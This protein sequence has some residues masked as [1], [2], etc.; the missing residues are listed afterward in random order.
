MLDRGALLLAHD[1]GLG[2]TVSS[3]AVAEELIDTGE[4]ESVLVICPASIKWQWKRQIEEFTDGALVMV[5]E[6]NQGERR[7]Q[8]RK[9]K[10]GDVEYV[11]MNYEQIVI[12]WDIVRF[13][14]WDAVFCDE[15]VAIKNPGAK[16]SRHVKRLRAPYKYGLSGKPIENRPEELFSIM[17]W[18]DPTVLGSFREF[19]RTYI[20]RKASG[21]V[22]YYKNLPLLRKTMDE[23]IHRKTRHD[24]DVRD[25]MPAVASK[26]YLIDFD[27][28]SQR[29]YNKIV[30]E[31]LEVIR[32]AQ[33]F[34]TFNL[35]SHYAGVDDGGPMGEIMPRLM[36]LRMLC[37]HPK[38]L[39]HSADQ[40]D[41][42][43]T[44]AGSKYIS[45]LRKTGAIDKLKSAPKMSVTLE[46]IDDIL[47]ASSRNKVV[48]FSFFKP[49][50]AIL[51]GNL[52]VDHEMFTGDL[53]PRERDA[54]LERFQKDTRCRVLLSSDAGGVGVD[55]PAANYLIS[56]D[57]P[58]SAGKFD[59]R[60]GRIVRIS[61]K[62]PEVTLLSMLMRNS[63][64]ERMFDMLQQKSA[65]GAAWLDGKRVNK[66]GEF[67]LTLGGLAEYLENHQ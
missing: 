20:R 26:S 61:T 6:G 2:K 12:D 13:L 46:E 36:A 15:I 50:L 62:W 18:I 67:H 33:S 37:D 24:K 55:M 8:Y 42:P 59:Q 64:E 4:A 19:D 63:I 17:E 25:Q 28:A 40:F 31:L 53:T 39:L 49:M 11:I 10:R 27:P 58:W 52:G 48:L 51:S 60:N 34:S 29:L 43:A 21:D 65:I 32:A 23:S 1:L 44:Q 30:R 35:M 54:S 38:L 45:D 57:L 56:Y 41:D 7:T 9:V 14:V 3:I 16:R 66:R 47:D 5:V 22:R